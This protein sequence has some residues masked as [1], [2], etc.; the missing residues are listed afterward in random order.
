MIMQSLAGRALLCLLAGSVFTLGLAPFDLKLLSLASMATFVIALTGQSWRQSLLLGWCYGLGFF[1]AGVSWVYVSINVYGHA[2]LA[3][4]LTLT[5]LFCAGLALLF[6]IQA[7]VFSLLRPTQAGLR[8]AL[9]ACLWVAFEWLRTWL[10]T[11]FPWL[12]AGYTVLDTVVAGWAPVIG[13]LGVSLLIAVTAAGVAE[14]VI[15]RSVS[16]GMLLTTWIVLLASTGYLLGLAEWTEPAGEERTVA[17]YQPNIAL[18]DTWDR[19]NAPILLGDF[20]AH[21]K[22]HAPSS[23]LVVWP[24]GALPFYFDQAP[25]YMAELRRIGQESDSTIVTG[26]PTRAGERR[27]NSI[28]SVGQSSQTYNKQKLVPFG[29][30]V[31]LED[32]LRG[33]IDFFNLP[34][35]NFSKGEAG[36]LPL[37]STIGSLAPFI[38]YEI[39][40]PDFVAKGSR[41]S[42]LLI[43]ISNDAWF[44]SSH[45]P[46]QHFQMARYR[47]LELQKQLIR[48]ANNG[49]T[50]II[51]ERGGIVGELPQFERATLEGQVTPREGLTP[52]ARFGSTPILLL[53]LI[54][55]LFIGIKAKRQRG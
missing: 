39:V 49:I 19:N 1:G 54:F 37:S 48:G 8:I 42:N 34:M 18:E 38:C 55:P 15:D 36:Q 47:A 6:A 45:G 52:F 41:S 53:S 35:S 32:S 33:A 26:M 2:P 40:Y 13:V 25:G 50:A 28:V 44:G 24:E 51:D 31:P 10:L 23:N 5:T 30:F 9:F 17:I 14:L 3:L 22:A 12:F 46:Y 4:A 7:A 27:F 43:T 29:E 16:R 21:A 11:G 20:L